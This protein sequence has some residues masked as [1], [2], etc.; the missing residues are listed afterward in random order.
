[1][2]YYVRGAVGGWCL[3]L[4]AIIRLIIFSVVDLLLQKK[5]CKQPSSQSRPRAQAVLQLMLS[6]ATWWFQKLFTI[7]VPCT[8]LRI[9]TSLGIFASL[10]IFT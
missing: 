1:M 9:F 3:L 8:S 5:G 6:Q 4:L 10:R 7:T 2:L